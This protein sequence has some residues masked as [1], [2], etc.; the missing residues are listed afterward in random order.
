MREVKRYTER[1]RDGSR[2]IQR[3]NERAQE[4]YTKRE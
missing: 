1:E 4:I 3:E 2:D